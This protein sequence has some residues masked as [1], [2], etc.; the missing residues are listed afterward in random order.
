MKPQI[1][2]CPVALLVSVER[3]M[4]EGRAR[5]GDRSWRTKGESARKLVG[6]VL[7]HAL[8]YYNGE[9]VDPESST[10]KLH[11]DGLAASVAILLDCIACGTLIDDRPPAGAGADLLRD[12]EYLK[13]DK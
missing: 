3:A 11:L 1:Q 5:Y 9:E 12:S 10:Q 4:V 8:A 7:R 13:G 6:A 2:N